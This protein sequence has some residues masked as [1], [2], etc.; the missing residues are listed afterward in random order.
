MQLMHLSVEIVFFAFAVWYFQ[1]VHSAIVILVLLSFAH[2]FTHGLAFDANCAS[3]KWE[4]FSQKLSWTL[5]PVPLDLNRS[6]LHIFN[7]SSSL[8]CA[9]VESLLPIKFQPFK[10]SINQLTPNIEDTCRTANLWLMRAVWLRKIFKKCS[11]WVWCIS[12][13]EHHFVRIFS[14]M[15]RDLHW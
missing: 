5:K 6:C 3:S 15:H 7:H 1:A 11:Y 14:K 9:W 4:I 12:N 10:N 8:K 13:Y 2:V